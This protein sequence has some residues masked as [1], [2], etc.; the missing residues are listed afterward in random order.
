MQKKK[1]KRKKERKRR[2]VLFFPYKYYC[3][4][5]TNLLDK[6]TTK[7]LSIIFIFYFLFYF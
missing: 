4:C 2:I 7:R 6:V 3:E 1:K 5:E